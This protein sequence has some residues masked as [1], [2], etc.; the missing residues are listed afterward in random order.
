MTITIS[1]ANT[2][3]RAAVVDAFLPGTGPYVT[4]LVALA[5]RGLRQMH[6]HGGT[7]FVQTSRGIRTPRGSVLRG[8]GDSLRYAAMAA[9]G[10]AR[11]PLQAQRDVLGGANA[12]A[13]AEATADRARDHRD[14]GAVALAAWAAAEVADTYRPELFE[15]LLAVLKSSDAVPT[16]DV[17][18]MIT[19]AI[20]AADLGDS[21]EVRDRAADRLAAAQGEQGLFPHTLPAR[22]SGRLRA[23]VGSFADQVYPLQSFAR[24]AA[25]QHSPEPLSAANRT[26][27]TLCDL[28]GTAGQ[29]WWHYDARTGAVVEKYPVYSVHQH[30]MAP[31][32]L[33]DL[34]SAGG[35][36]HSENI[37]RGV[38][39]LRIHPEVM[40]DLVSPVHGVVWRKV[41]RREPKKASRSLSAVTTAVRPGAH[42]PGVDRL[43]PPERIDYECRPYELGW[44]LYAWL[45]G[46]PQHS[47]TELDNR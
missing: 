35:E 33:F 28:Q 42:L 45:S 37:A 24:L 2:V 47:S 17:A 4:S 1:S 40:D 7:R 34:L 41:G 23:H 9:L 5:Q 31:M 8:E 26:A 14:P 27:T 18:W 16:V 21:I 22:A 46:S 44:L 19:A 39:W 13:L 43:F 6:S 12:V 20:A 3:D 15:L 11:L 36:D 30:A 32:V 38:N 25:V 10:I 29:W